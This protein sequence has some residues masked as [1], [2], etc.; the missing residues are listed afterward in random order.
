MA[1]QTK[2]RSAE[3]KPAPRIDLGTRQERRAA[4]IAAGYVPQKAPDKVY[5]VVKRGRQYSVTTKGSKPPVGWDFVQ[6]FE[7]LVFSDAMDKARK[8]ASKR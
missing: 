4:R 2:D 3:R 1:T 5:M 7:T 8:L 6:G